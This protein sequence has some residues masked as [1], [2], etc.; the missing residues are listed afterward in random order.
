MSLNYEKLLAMVSGGYIYFY[1]NNQDDEYCAY[2]YLKDNKIELNDK[3][4]EI[5]L[6]N[7]FGMLQI[8]FLSENKYKKWIKCLNERINEMKNSE[9]EYFNDDL[10]ND[11]KINGSIISENS[12][13]IIQENSKND[14]I[15]FGLDFL[16]KNCDLNLYDI[17]NNNSLVSVLDL[18]LDDE[19]NKIFTMNLKDFHINLTFTNDKTMINFSIL[20]IKLCDCLNKTKDFNLM[21]CNDN[22]FNNKLIN[23]NIIFIDKNSKYYKNNDVEVYLDFGSNISPCIIR[24]VV[25]DMYTYMVL[26]VR[27]KEQTVEK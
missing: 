4:F 21:L 3:E 5:K 18:K 1:K 25:D 7:N 20:G 19:L 12:S 13:I 26:P 22:F 9:D 23:L 6:Y 2:Y 24:S 14:V 8:K 17:E 16:I 11:N 27:L 15:H 10:N